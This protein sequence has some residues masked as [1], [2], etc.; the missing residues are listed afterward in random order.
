[1]RWRLVK[2]EPDAPMRSVEDAYNEEAGKSFLTAKLEDLVAWGARQFHLAVSTSAFP[3][4]MWRWPRRS[5][6]ATTF[7]VSAPR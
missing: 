3:A 4:A 1:M 7:P 6:R 5:L 2:A